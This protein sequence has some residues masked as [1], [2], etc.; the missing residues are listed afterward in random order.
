MLRIYFGQ[1]QELVSVTY[2]HN[3]SG[4]TKNKLLS[5][6]SIDILEVSNSYL[7]MQL[8]FERPDL[9]K[10]G[11]EIEVYFD[12][13]FIKLQDG[14][15]LEVFVPTV[16]LLYNTTLVTLTKSESKI[17]NAATRI[18]IASTITTIVTRGSL[19]Q[20]WETINGI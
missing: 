11:D 7:S 8:T 9:V 1:I 12:F 15:R 18:L 5:S 20:L 3:G 14:K 10:S 13:D 6:Y 17:E 19:S 4:R 2:R 16:E